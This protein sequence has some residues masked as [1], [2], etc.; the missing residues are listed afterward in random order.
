MSVVF[1]TSSFGNI[2]R[3]LTPLHLCY[4]KFPTSPK[5]SGEKIT[6]LRNG[7]NIHYIYNNRFGYINYHLGSINDMRYYR[8]LP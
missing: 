4:Q 7:L 5:S 6:Y 1:P 2:L 3:A 8:I